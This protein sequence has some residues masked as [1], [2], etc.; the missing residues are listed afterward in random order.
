M[1]VVTIIFFF[2][3]FCVFSQKAIVVD[4]VFVSHIVNKSMYYYYDENRS[5][6]SNTIE[7]K[8]FN[9]PN[10]EET[11]LRKAKLWFVQNI[12]NRDG[13]NLNLIFKLKTYAIEA[14]T[15]YRKEEDKLVEVYRLKSRLEKEIDI[16]IH[17]N[18]S[19]PTTYYFEIAFTTS[20]YL[21][22]ELTTVANSTKLNNLRLVQ[23]SVYYGFVVMV[24]LINLFFFISTKNRFFLYYCFLLVGI[25]LSIGHID[26]LFHYIFGDVNFYFSDVLFLNWLL[27]VSHILFTTRALQLKKYYPIMKKINWIVI[28]AFTS[29]FIIHL[30]TK[31]LFLFSIAK[32][33]NITSLFGYWFFGVLLFR[34]QIY[35]KF[36]TVAYFVLLASTVLFQIPLNFGVSSFGFSAEQYKIGSIVEMLIFLYA[37]SYRHKKVEIERQNMQTILEEKLETTYEIAMENRVIKEKI[38]NTKAN[39]LSEEEVYDLF[40]DK[41]N[42]TPRE[43]EICRFIVKGD[44]NEEIAIEA[45]IKITTVK[46]HV[47]NI[48][49]KLKIKNRTE[50]LALYISFK[51]SM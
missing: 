29:V 14:L 27:V 20:V 30:F 38:W 47:S 9:K 15:L 50:V 3:S 49:K 44:S 24:F 32:I 33:M 6:S 40:V 42:L 48:F 22:L 51:E 1:K 28:I 21:P 18:E 26:G 7:T 17:L 43:L 39:T 16:P 12:E 5:E 8:N 11:R 35:A 41:F 2:F 13:K 19:G 45:A 37:I 4:S 10:E 31:K 36:Y 46:Y 34:K 23:Y 25:N